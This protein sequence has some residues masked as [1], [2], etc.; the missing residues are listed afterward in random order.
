MRAYA[1]SKIH[2]IHPET[3][4]KTDFR[5]TRAIQACRCSAICFPLSSEWGLECH[6]TKV[7]IFR[8]FDVCCVRTKRDKVRTRKITLWRI[9]VLRTYARTTYPRARPRA[10]RPLRLFSMNVCAP[11]I[12]PHRMTTRGHN[13]YFCHLLAAKMRSLFHGSFAARQ[14]EVTT[15]PRRRRGHAKT[16]VETKREC[17]ENK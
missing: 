13:A 16:H 10:V 3:A 9:C 7:G 4:C 8:L 6:V 17:F 11:K 14:Q 12:S 15:P 5:V 1:Y 2:P